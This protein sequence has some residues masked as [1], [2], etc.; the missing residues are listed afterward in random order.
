MVSFSFI[1]I[2]K[3]LHEKN[4]LLL[5][6]I[7]GFIVNVHAQGNVIK[8]YKKTS[9]MVPMRDGVKLFTMILTPVGAASAVPVLITRTPY[10][11]DM[12]V[13]DGS[14]FD[15][16]DFGGYYGDMAKEGYYFYFPGYTRQIQKRRQHGNSPAAYACKATRDY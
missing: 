9:V 16:A 14:S 1:F 3:L 12:D 7:I 6:T 15:F 2:T 5:F 10:G 11:A 8:A 4:C 13:P